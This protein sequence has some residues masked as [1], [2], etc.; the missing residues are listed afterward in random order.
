MG[1]VDAVDVDL[2]NLEPRGEGAGE[3][4]VA[5]APGFLLT[6]SKFPGGWCAGQPGAGFAR[7]PQ[8]CR[9]TGVPRPSRV[10]SGARAAAPC[11]IAPTSRALARAGATSR[12]PGLAGLPSRAGTPGRT[13]AWGLLGRQA[14]PSWSLGKRAH[15]FAATFGGFA[16]NNFFFKN[17]TREGGHWQNGR[18]GGE[19][20]RAVRGRSW[21]WGET[22]GS[23]G[24]ASPAPE[25]EPVLRDTVRGPDA[26]RAGGSLASGLRSQGELTSS[27]R[28]R[29]PRHHGAGDSAGRCSRVGQL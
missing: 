3:R 29:D 25:A 4:Q 12:G 7:R 14:P 24:S 9:A 16:L 1:A 18:P 22:V 26:P 20:L 17:Q 2:G 21:A 13:G 15:P 5:G 23:A 11:C 28:S 19:V 10:G 6:S 8:P 27:L